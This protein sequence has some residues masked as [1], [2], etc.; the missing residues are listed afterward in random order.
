MIKVIFLKQRL[1]FAVDEEKGRKKRLRRCRS[2]R[3]T[4]IANS[5]SPITKA[6][7]SRAKGEKRKAKS[8]KRKAKIEGE[9]L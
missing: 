4:Q 6:Q 2:L 9:G 1:F 5:Q 8:E 7:G 3:E